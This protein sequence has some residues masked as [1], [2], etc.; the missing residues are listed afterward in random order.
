LA[1]AECDFG[2]DR[3]FKKVWRR[4][5]KTLEIIWIKAMRTLIN[6]ATVSASP[7]TGRG[8]CYLAFAQSSLSNQGA[9]S[10]SRK[11]NAI[12]SAG[13]GK[14]GGAVGSARRY[15]ETKAWFEHVFFREMRIWG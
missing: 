1:I 15:M 2:P 7:I 3:P 10:Y 8:H 5:F 6:A 9:I 11:L 14:S 12:G 13:D 4:A